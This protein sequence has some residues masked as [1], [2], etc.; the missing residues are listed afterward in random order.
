[1]PK[2]DYCGGGGVVGGRMPDHTYTAMPCAYCDANKSSPVLTFK[3]MRSPMKALPAKV[4]TYLPCKHQTWT[5]WIE[6]EF[7]GLR[8]VAVIDPRYRCFLWSEEGLAVSGSWPL[9]KLEADL[10]RLSQDLRWAG[11]RE[12]SAGVALELLY[13][14]SNAHELVFAYVIHA[15]PVTALLDG[16]DTQIQ[17][18][19][20]DTLHEAFKESHHP[21]LK[22]VPHQV[23]TTRP[24][25]EPELLNKAC[26]EWGVSSILIKQNLARWGEKGCWLRFEED[27]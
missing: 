11:D 17:V 10:A 5:C 20:R 15:M 2:C 14:P 19:R 7:K 1:M 18:M 8:M 6:P 23:V 24:T 21:F 27:F 9:I 4:E 12:W 16:V 22:L 13:V 25:L 3:A 26:A